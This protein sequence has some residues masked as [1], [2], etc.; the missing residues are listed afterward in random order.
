MA[1]VGGIEHRQQIEQERRQRL[2]EGE[3]TLQRAI[4]AYATPI[5]KG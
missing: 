1:F 3:V 2:V 4:D 5:R